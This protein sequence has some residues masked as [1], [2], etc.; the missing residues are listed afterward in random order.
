MGSPYADKLDH[1]ATVKPPARSAVGPPLQH[2]FRALD[3]RLEPKGQ[4]RPPAISNAVKVRLIATG[5]PGLFGIAAIDG[6]IA[7][8]NGDGVVDMPA[9]PRLT[10]FNSTLRSPWP[11]RSFAASARRLIQFS[12]VFVLG[13]TAERRCSPKYRY[14]QWG[15]IG[16]RS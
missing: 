1:D 3:G 6:Y 9:R 8:G 14:V 7:I 16:E 11:Y 2:A 12:H 4:E 13:I 5:E 15:Q 10:A